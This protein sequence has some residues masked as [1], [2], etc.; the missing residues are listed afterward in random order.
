M[1]TKRVAAALAAVLVLAACSARDDGVD[2]KFDGYPGES[3]ATVNANKAGFKRGDLQNLDRRLRTSNSSCFVVTRNGKVAYQDYYRG[4][5]AEAVG[6]AYSMSKSFTS[7]LVGIAAD[8]GK[9]DLDDKASKYITEWQGTKSEDVTIRDLLSNTSGRHWDLITDYRKMAFTVPDKTTFAVGL[10]QDAPPGKVW[11]YNNSAIQTLQLVLKKATG[12]EPTE[13]AQQYLFDPLAM[14]DTTWETDDAGNTLMFSGI[15]STCLDLARFGLMMLHHGEWK[16]KQ[17]VSADYVKEATTRSSKLN[18]AYGLLW[19][20]N[21]KGPVLGTS[22]AMGGGGGE[23][24]SERLAPRAPHNAFWAIGA[25]RQ[26]IAV[27]PSEGIV[28][29]RMGAAPVDKD[30]LTADSFT[31]DLVD[32]IRK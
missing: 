10:G 17:V 14:H 22:A 28:A 19:W 30:S 24:D 23:P 1:T 26:M 32:S 12:T 21:D 25:G 31:G 2:K 8:Q 20:I 18:A 7:I 27:L 4:R 3:W 5:D 16:G 29:V 6:S 15:V 9:L 11:E 13:Y